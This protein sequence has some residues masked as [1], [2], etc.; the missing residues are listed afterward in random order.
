M[1]KRGETEAR[2][3][4]CSLTNAT[5]QVASEG[6]LLGMTGVAMPSA[7]ITLEADEPLIEFL[8]FRPL[9][10]GSVSLSDSVDMDLGRSPLLRRM[11]L[12]EGEAG[13]EVLAAG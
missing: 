8:P 3:H 10:L 11:G 12:S 5:L 7:F 4:T 13:A 9:P 6:P 1:K 2:P